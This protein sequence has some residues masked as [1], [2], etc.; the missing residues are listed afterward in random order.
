MIKRREERIEDSHA[1]KKFTFLAIEKVMG[2]FCSL[3][4]RSMDT[5][6]EKSHQMVEKMMEKYDMEKKTDG[7]ETMVEDTFSQRCDVIASTEIISKS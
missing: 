1:G 4:E 7:N 6:M 3:M 5:T 2:K